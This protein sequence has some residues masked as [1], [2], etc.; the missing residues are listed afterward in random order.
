MIW[1][2]NQILIF[3][4]IK[5]MGNYIEYNFILKIIEWNIKSWLTV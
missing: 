2:K 5:Y 1:K 4:Y 3:Y